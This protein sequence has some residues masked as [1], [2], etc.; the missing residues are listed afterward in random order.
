MKNLIPLHIFVFILIQLPMISIAQYN[1]PDE[2]GD[3]IYT[4]DDTTHWHS[5]S[6]DTINNPDNIWQIGH[7]QKNTIDNAFSQPNVIIT[8][9]IDSYPPNNLSIFEIVHQAQ[10]GFIDG[11][12]AVFSGFYYVDSDSL[13]DYGTIEFS[14]DDGATWINLL[15]DTVY[16][17]YYNWFT[18]KPILTGSS[19]NW[20]FFGIQ[21]AGFKEIFEIDS[22]T[23]VRYKISFFSD[24]V[25]NNKDGLAFD[26]LHFKDYLLKINNLDEPVFI[27]ISPNPC[28]EIL[29]VSVKDFN[30]S[31]LTLIL[32]DI[33]GEIIKH[34][35]LLN[36][37]VN[38]I[39]MNEL[40]PGI[41]IIIVKNKT[42]IIY[43]Q[44]LIKL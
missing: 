41:Y 36:N 8:D 42:K 20:T 38:E 25:N 28:Q 29:S 4:F 13:F 2:W 22:T 43:Q 7:T 19:I 11:G 9:T 21:L 34:K 32:L 35:T 18:E 37:N 3:Y 23:I 30:E 14:P 26:D 5:L 10:D 1:M 33:N 12:V 27:D 17:D 6:I 40:T 16:S 15:T 31:K 24:V 44:K 39:N